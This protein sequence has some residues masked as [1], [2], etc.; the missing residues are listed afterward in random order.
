[1][2]MLYHVRKLHIV[3]RENVRT[4]VSELGPLQL[5]RHRRVGS[6]PFGGHG[7][8]EIVRLTIETNLLTSVCALVS[9]C[10]NPL[11][12]LQLPMQL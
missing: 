4:D 8:F 12:P 9:Y 11:R 10:T 1:M 2:A 7:L 6:W 3:Q 5:A